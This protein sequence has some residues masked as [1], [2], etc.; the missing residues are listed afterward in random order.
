MPQSVT[1][2]L[3]HYC[4]LCPEP[5][6]TW[7]TARDQAILSP[8]V[9]FVYLVVILNRTSIDCATTK[10]TARPAAATKVLPRIEHGLNTDF[11]PYPFVRVPSVFHPWLPYPD[12]HPLRR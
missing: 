6:P 5:V 7:P 8:F 1:H 12:L 4:Y 10:H 3:N 9:W 2:V 11:Q